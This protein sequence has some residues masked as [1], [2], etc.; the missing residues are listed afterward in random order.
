MTVEEVT[1]ALEGG[2]GANFVEHESGFRGGVYFRL[3]SDGEEI[4]VQPNSPDV[5]GYLPEPD[6]GHWKTLV[7][8]N[9]SVRWEYL[10]AS[11]VVAALDHL[12]TEEI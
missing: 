4:L 11:F 5:E 3:A 10:V 9:H 2:I 8:V 7:Y 6:F 1:R 12:R